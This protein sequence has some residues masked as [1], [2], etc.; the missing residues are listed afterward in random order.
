M[1]KKLIAC[2]FAAGVT[3]A[4]AA[5]A[6][7]EWGLPEEEVVRFEAQ[8]VDILCELTGDCPDNCARVY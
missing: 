2:V 6:A 3:F 7:Q 1:G 4:G 8:V 5:Q